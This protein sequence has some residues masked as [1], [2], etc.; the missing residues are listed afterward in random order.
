MNNSSYYKDLEKRIILKLFN[1]PAILTSS[2][3]D[4]A[5]LH[6]ETSD[7]IIIG[8]LKTRF[9]AYPDYILEELKYSRLV[10]KAQS[11]KTD[12]Q[13]LIIYIN[14]IYPTKDVYTWNISK[15]Q[16]TKDLENW[17]LSKHTANDFERCGDIVNKSIWLLNPSESV[18]TRKNFIV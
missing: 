5:D 11:I 9:R 7:M 14:Y 1:N 8:E 4:P 12:K 10:E 6:I 13:I 18:L 16:P 2:T 17:R 3:F 15:F